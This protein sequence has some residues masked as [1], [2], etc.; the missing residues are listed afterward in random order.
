MILM[1]LSWL[2]LAG[3]WTWAIFNSRSDVW[4]VVVVEYLVVSLS[5]LVLLIIPFR[6]VTK[7]DWRR[8]ASV[9]QILGCWLL[10]VPLVAGSI[11]YGVHLWNIWGTFTDGN[12]Y[13][14]PLV[15][16]LSYLTP[17]ASLGVGRLFILWRHGFAKSRSIVLAA[18]PF[19][20]LTIALCAFGIWFFH[21][22]DPPFRLS[23]FVWWFEP[24][25]LLGI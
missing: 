19:A 25:R 6:L 20:T 5:I 9:F 10:I 12:D 24:F 3:F 15:F 14:D 11:L 1:V 23:Y 13:F 17:L 22:Q 4:G 16:I 8:I 21:G 2:F 7:H 18:V